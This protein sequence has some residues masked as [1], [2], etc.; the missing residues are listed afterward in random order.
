[1]MSAK[2]ACGEEERITGVSAEPAHDNADPNRRTL[3]RIALDR[4]IDVLE[5]SLIELSADCVRGREEYQGLVDKIP[6]VVQ[7]LANQVATLKVG[8]DTKPEVLDLASRVAAM[9]TTIKDAGHSQA[10]KQQPNFEDIHQILEDNGRIKGQF[11]KFTQTLEDFHKALSA[12]QTAHE[13]W[14]KNDPIQSNALLIQSLEAVENLK[15]RLLFLETAK[16]RDVTVGNAACVEAIDFLRKRI[17]VLEAPKRFQMVDPVQ[18]FQERLSKL[19]AGVG[20]FEDV[21]RKTEETQV[22]VSTAVGSMNLTDARL[23][24]LGMVVL[25]ASGRLGA[26]ED[27]LPEVFQSRARER[28]RGRSISGSPDRITRSLRPTTGLPGSQDRITRSQGAGLQGS[29]LH[30]AREQGYMVTGLGLQRSP[31]VNSQD[32]SHNSAPHEL[33]LL[34]EAAATTESRLRRRLEV[35]KELS[36]ELSVTATKASLDRRGSEDTGLDQEPDKAS[37]EKDAG[38][39]QTAIGPGRIKRRC[40]TEVAQPELL[41]QE[42]HPGDLDQPIVT[43]P[44]IVMYQELQDETDAAEDLPYQYGR[45]PPRRHPSPNRLTPGRNLSSGA[46]LSLG[47]QRPPQ[48]LQDDDRQYSPGPG[49]WNKLAA[50]PLIP[51]SVKVDKHKDVLASFHHGAHC[52]QDAWRIPHHCLLERYKR[53]YQRGHLHLVLYP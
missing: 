29:G 35:I 9:E 22:M 20:C 40:W 1:M 36:K 34:E 21:K 7:D 6:A 51:T 31:E 8:V 50:S 25:Q 24:Q 13:P 49:V 32:S 17:D 53:R 4:R 46:R 16:D 10:Q 3:D 15:A 47:S 52:P 39:F 2:L 41:D 44:G 23:E 28:E 5:N 37:I 27:A 11:S 19:E 30:E 18:N 14:S 42:V 45:N 12:L 38:S 48:R 43:R 33:Q 26:V